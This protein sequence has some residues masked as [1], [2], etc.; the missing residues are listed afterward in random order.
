MKVIFALLGLVASLGALVCWVLILIDAFKS[1]IWK[2]FVG[3][4]CG[5][6]LLY[7]AITEFQHE[8]KWLIVGGTFGGFIIASIFQ[9]LGR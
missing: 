8:K 3:L 5:L 6:Y 4:L 1:A 9:M 2:G 7:F